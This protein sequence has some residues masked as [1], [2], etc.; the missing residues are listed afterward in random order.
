MMKHMVNAGLFFLFA[1]AAAAQ[2]PAAPPRPPADP[3]LALE[4]EVFDYP[5]GNRRDPF[6][7]LTS[8]DTQGPLISE[9]TLTGIFFDR[10]NQARSIATLRDLNKKE[11]RVRRGDTVGNAVVQLIDSRRVVFSVKEF[12]MTRQEVLEIKLPK[13][14]A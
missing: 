9:L 7:P 3:K 14:G 6:K 13:A 4:R 5:G 2:A 12:G 8:G 10:A 1:T 11:Y